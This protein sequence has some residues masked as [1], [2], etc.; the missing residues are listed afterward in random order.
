ME[1]LIVILTILTVASKALK[2]IDK[3]KV[4]DLLKV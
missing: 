2:T 1:N 3:E 4:N